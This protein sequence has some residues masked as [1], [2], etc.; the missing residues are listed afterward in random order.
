MLIVWYISLDVSKLLGGKVKNSDVCCVV[1]LWFVISFN[2][3]WMLNIM[4]LW[5]CMVL[6][7][8]CW[9]IFVS[10]RLFCME[11]NCSRFCV[12]L[13]NK[14]C[15]FVC[16]ILFVFVVDWSIWL[17]YFLKGMCLN[18]LFRIWECK[19][20]FLLFVFYI[21]F[22]CFCVFILSLYMYIVL[23]FGFEY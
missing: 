16:E 8:V 20:F 17:V 9:S 11:L 13:G 6:R 3:V 18:V 15:R 21:M 23:E 10:C 14:C 4:C 12:F 2:W 7:F 5:I 19:L 22:L 1:F